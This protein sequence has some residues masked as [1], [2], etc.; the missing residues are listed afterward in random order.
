[1]KRI[2]LM[3]I[4]SYFLVGLAWANPGPRVIPEMQECMQSHGSPAQYEAV[5]KKYCDP[6]IIR[7]A[8]GL[9]VIKKPYVV[10]VEQKGRT[11]CYTV[12]GTTEETS[13]EIPADTTQT[14]NVCWENG[15]VVS[16]EFYGAKSRVYQEIIPQMRECLRSHGSQKEYE[17]VLKKYCDPGIIRK[18]MALLVI[19]APYVVKTE[20]RG[21]MITYTVE[22]QTIDTSSEIPADTVQRYRVSWKNGRMVAIDFLGPKKPTIPP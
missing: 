9:L 11:L 19:K 17:A 22:G 18:A 8:M 6:G 15:R 4:I 7:K 3:V 10:K 1:M 21:P 12:E 14:Y 16:L 13:S 20:K 2:V 5:L